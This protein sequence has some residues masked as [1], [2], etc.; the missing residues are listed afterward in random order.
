MK[1]LFRVGA[2]TCT[3][4]AFAG[5]PSSGLKSKEI[6]IVMGLLGKKSVEKRGRGLACD[7]L[8]LVGSA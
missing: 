1:I 3:A 4:K 8:R 5:L 7:G 6:E 2:T